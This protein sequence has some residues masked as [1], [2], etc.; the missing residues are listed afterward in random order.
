[1]PSDKFKHKQEESKN[2][3]SLLD[4]IVKE[5]DRGEFLSDDFEVSGHK[6]H[7]KT[8]NEEENN[9]CYQFVNPANAVTIATTM[10]LPMIAM[11]TRSI[12]DIPIEDVLNHKWMEL[13][14]EDQELLNEANDFARKYFIAEHYMQFLSQRSPS[15]IKDLWVCYELLEARKVE[16]QDSLKKS[17]G[18][19][20]EKEK[21]QNMTESS[22]NGEQ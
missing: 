5:A 18:E 8:V 20:S 3:R 19:D 7:I 13:S 2:F 16:V 12:D 21:K 1:M 9:W 22:P 14:L 15:L 11:S 10:R 17:S 4:D 6:Y